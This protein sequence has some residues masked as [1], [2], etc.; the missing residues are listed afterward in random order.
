MMRGLETSKL[1]FSP[2][3]CSRGVEWYEC[4]FRG[5]RWPIR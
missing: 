5:E 2:S 4:A 3:A 1:G